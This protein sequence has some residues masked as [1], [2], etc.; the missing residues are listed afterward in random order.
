MTVE[1]YETY[2]Q[3]LNRNMTFRIILPDGYKTSEKEYAVIY[4]QDGQDLLRDEEATDEISWNYEKYYSRYK[5]T[6]PDIIIVG[7]DCPDTNIARTRLYAPYHKSFVGNNRNFE[8]E[9]DGQGKEYVSWLVNELKPWVDNKYRTRPEKEFT[10]IGG[11][12]TAGIT[13][14]YAVLTYPE[15]FT[16]VITISAAYYHWYKFLEQTV[17]EADLNNLRYIYMDV[18]GNDQGR[19]TQQ[20]EFILGNQRMYDKFQELGFD[21]NQV[22]FA[23]FEKDHHIHRDFGRRFP[24]ALRWVFQ[25]IT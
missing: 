24:D 19:M 13:A 2:S 4:M 6:L 10:A 12:S 21:E 1:L 5:K 7:V 20:E 15:I 9:I 16:R 25:D 18:G 14:M 22:E 23:V 8:D 3:N 17:E 11:S